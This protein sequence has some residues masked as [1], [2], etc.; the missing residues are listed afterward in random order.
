MLPNFN[1]MNNSALTTTARIAQ[2]IHAENSMAQ[3]AAK[4]RGRK[5]KPD[6]PLTEV[7]NVGRI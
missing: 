1:G 3:F 7:I 6:E 4:K 2:I 5:K